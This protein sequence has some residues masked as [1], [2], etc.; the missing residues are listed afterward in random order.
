MRTLLL[1]DDDPFASRMLE[2]LFKKD[3]QI[4]NETVM[5]RVL[6]HIRT[7][8]PDLILLNLGLR[9]TEGESAFHII[10]QHAPDVPVIVLSPLNLSRTGRTLVKNGAFW[11]LTM[12]LNTDD[13]ERIM[14]IVMMQTQYRSS[15]R[16]VQRDF[17]QLDEGIARISTSLQNNLPEEFTFDRDDLIQNII[18]LLGDLLQVE[19]VSLM[20]LDRQRGELRIKAAKGLDR[21]VI[22]NTIKTLGEGI[23]G[24]VAREGKPLLIKNVDE[25]GQFSES[26]F[27]QQYSTKSLVCVPLRAGD[28]VVGVLS[29]NNK[30][31]G[32]PF[33]EHDL[34]MATIFSHLLLLT[35]QNAQFHYDR[36]RSLAQ[37]SRL[38]GLN[39]K[40]SATLEPK[41]LFHTLLTETRALITSD[42]AFLFLLDEN[43]TGCGIYYLDGD[44]FMESILSSSSL[45]QWAAY[46][47][48]PVISSDPDGREFQI[49]KNLTRREILSW[50]SVPIVMQDKLAG[51]LELASPSPRS[52]KETDKQT[53]SQIAQ[54][55]ALAINN[56]RLYIKLLHSLKDVSEARK[57]VERIRRDQYL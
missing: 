3:W 9:R 39:R 13:L 21:Y 16:E 11:Q 53:L 51:S 23:A 15:V 32:Y 30:R 44:R 56:S 33:D 24:W 14:E 46:R 40:L 10:R 43:R 50:I 42:S 55:A 19:K 52:F 4:T 49:L 47:T 20:L 54:Q 7:S 26:P 18:D 5:D 36:E 28:T 12:P 37:D 17:A 6:D 45:G 1:I 41:V 27:F 22:E 57:E 35:L 8:P 34:Y 31:T 2:E 29:A 38:I 25:S 48:Q